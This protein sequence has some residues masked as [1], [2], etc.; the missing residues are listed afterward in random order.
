MSRAGRRLLLAAAGGLSAL[1]GQG[2]ARAGGLVAERAFPPAGACYGRRYDAAHLARHPGQVVTGLH[3]GGSSR[4]LIRLRAEAGRVDPELTLRLRIDF[5]DGTSSEGEV[6][7]LEERGRI[8]RCGRNASCAGD[9]ALE[10]LPGGR[11]AVVNDDAASRM[12]T[13]ANAR[14]GFS[15]DAGCPPGGRAGRFVPP[16]AQNRVFHLERLPLAACA[17]GPSR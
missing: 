4:D 6:G 11:L 7:C 9:F 3:L 12:P 10:A 5:A 16:D 17:P 13:T 15:P 1:L 2:S 14:A 8:R